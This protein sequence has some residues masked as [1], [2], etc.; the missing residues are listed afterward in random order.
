MDVNAQWALQTALLARLNEDP[1]LG[2]VLGSPVRLYDDIPDQP[3][4]PFVTFDRANASPVNAE[5]AGALE[6]ILTLKV[7]SRYG[8]R[9]EAL[10]GLHALRNAIDDAAFTLDGHQLVN[11]HTTFSDVFRVRTSRIFEAI[12]NLRAVTEPLT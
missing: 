4:F 9:R 2:A 10:A 1:N 6:H 3:Q 7:W 11:I 5:H 12:L 8:G